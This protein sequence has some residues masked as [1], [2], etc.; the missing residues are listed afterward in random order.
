[1]EATA[2]GPADV[3]ADEPGRPSIFVQLWHKRLIVALT[4]GVTLFVVVGL[5][6]LL[7]VSY[8]ATGSLIVADREP[9]A[10]SSSPAYA[11]RVG[12]PSDI[13]STI[14]LIRSPRLLRML[15]VEP[16]IGDVIE[17]DC[18]AAGRHLVNRFRSIDCSRLP[19]DADAQLH[20]VQDRFSI[21]AV[22]R[23]R[24]IS[25]DYKSPVPEVAQAMVNGLLQ[26]FLNDEHAKLRHSRDEAVEWL[27]QRLSQIDTE[28]QHDAAGIEAFR[29]LHGLVRSAGG[30]LSSERL[31][32][33]AQQL[34]EAKAVQADAE[35]RLQESRGGG[36]GRQP[37]ESR[38]IADLK[39]QL[40]QATSLSAGA[41]Q[42]FGA[43]NPMLLPYRRQEADISARLAAETARAG[44]AAR[45]SLEAAKARVDDAARELTGRTEAASQAAEAETQIAGM[46]RDL[47]IKR[48]SYVDLSQRLSQ[49]ETE[50]R[51][52]E[53]GTQLVNLAEL[54]PRPSFPQRTPFLI[55]GLMMAAVLATSA[56]LLTY[57]PV[58]SGPIALG[59]TYTRIPILAQ[60]PELRLRRVGKKELVGRQRDFPLAAAISLLESHPP[61]LEAVR[62][63]HAR[64][65]LAG[66]GGKHRT[67]LIASE[68]AGEGKSFV[69]LA[70]ARMAQAS[71]RR[72]LV[73]ETCLREPFFQE[74]LHGPPT[75]GLAGYLRGGQAELVQ[76][77]AV[78]GVDFLLAGSMMPDST[79]LL[80][81]PR[82]RKLLEWADTYDL[83]LIDSAPVSEL[84]DAALLAPRVDGV[85]FCLRAGRPPASQALN[86]LPEMQ[87]ANGNVVGLTLTFVPDERVSTPSVSASRRLPARRELQTGDA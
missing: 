41:A 21:A 15:F 67:L 30:P 81:G 63:L 70:L 58:Q 43:Q 55:G 5:L 16:G 31:T 18:A 75:P 87:R 66:F 61:L 32:Q 86:S 4:F 3:P 46:V 37:V 74:A 57:K 62:I 76:L 27:R 71:G 65:T 83:V 22:G 68:V 38:T 13:E 33:A 40:A 8:L 85:V 24:V 14:L 10:G 47:E 78:P 50:R 56:G 23:S 2:D 84:M 17:A 53:P 20:W 36:G 39:Q 19:G 7:P 59:R 82:F 54:P 35:S 73:I 52:L 34:A 9:T 25:I 45:R 12:D 72:V 60:V 44:E 26:T 51:A 6:Y 48:G 69:T 80:S 11:Q 29:T 64:L 79:E 77:G 49:L 1:M 28:L 42:R